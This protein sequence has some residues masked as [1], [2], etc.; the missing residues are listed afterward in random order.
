MYSP[1]RQIEDGSSNAS[2]KAIGDAVTQKIIQTVVAFLNTD[3]GDII[4]GVQEK[5][6]KKILG[7]I[8]ANNCF[9]T[10]KEGK[11]ISS[12]KLLKDCGDFQ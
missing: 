6:V 1:V 8:L 11:I 9:Q 4:I 2:I 12:H 7:L 3:G 10:K 5:P